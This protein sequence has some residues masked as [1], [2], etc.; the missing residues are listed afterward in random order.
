MHPIQQS[1]QTKILLLFTAL[2]LAAGCSL[3]K[4]SA[5]NRGLQNLTAHYNILFNANE[6]LREKQEAYAASYVDDYSELLSVYQDTISRA[7]A[8]DK[9]LTE[10]KAKANKI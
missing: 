10:V 1:R 8:P 9:D 3:E 4:K 7:D 6:I 2:L 5:L